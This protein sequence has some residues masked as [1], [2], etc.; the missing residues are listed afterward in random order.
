MVSMRR[1]RRDRI[2]LLEMF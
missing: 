1:F 2:P